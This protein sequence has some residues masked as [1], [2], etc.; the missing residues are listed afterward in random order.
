MKLP[1]F[2]LVAILCNVGAQLSMKRAASSITSMLDVA[3]WLSPWLFLSVV[4]YGGSFIL[5]ARVLSANALSI[6]SPI[7]AGA[8]FV[9]IALTSVLVLNESMGA[10]KFGGMALILAGI[11]VL[12]RA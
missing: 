5:T 10:Q 4:L 6:A 7:M 1:L 8:T 9:A 2:A 12:S 11:F 3:G